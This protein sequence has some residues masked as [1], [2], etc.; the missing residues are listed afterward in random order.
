[1]H[2]VS[3]LF[4]HCNGVHYDG[5]HQASHGHDIEQDKGMRNRPVMMWE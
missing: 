5:Y 3:N 1:M 4:V 2:M